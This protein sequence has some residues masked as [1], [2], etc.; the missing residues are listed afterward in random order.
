[1]QRVSLDPLLPQRSTDVMGFISMRHFVLLSLALLA[2]GSVYAHDS[3]KARASDNSQEVATTKAMR[4]VPRGATITD[5]SCK[6]LNYVFQ[7]RWRCTVTYS[8]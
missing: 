5:T 8:D 4:R 6:K 7:A 1:M 3:H 2:Q